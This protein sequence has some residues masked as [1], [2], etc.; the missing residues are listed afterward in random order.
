[1]ENVLAHHRLM[2]ITSRKKATH[3]AFI[4][5]SKAANLAACR[6]RQVNA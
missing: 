4:S 2:V 5:K 6:A 1:M 3:E